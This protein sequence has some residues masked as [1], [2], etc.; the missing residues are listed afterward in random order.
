MKKK[1]I[2]IL[3]STGSIGIQAL[4]IIEHYSD[5]FRVV[6]LSTKGNIRLLK[7]Q[8]LKFK[9][10]IVSVEDEKLRKVLVKELPARKPE[11]LCNQE[12]LTSIA[13]HKETDVVMVAVVGSVALL[14]VVSAIN[15]GKDIALANKEALVVGGN[16][17][18][19][20][21][22]KKGVKILPVDSEQSAI[23]QC[24]EGNKR[25]MVKKIYLT[26]SGGPFYNRHPDSF[27]NISIEDALKH[28]RWSMGKKISIDSASMM[29]KGLEI[30]EAKWLFDI[31]IDRIEIII[32]PQ[33]IIHSMVEYLDGSIIAQ[34][35]ITD[36]RVPILYALTYPERIDSYLPRLNLIDVSPLS[37]ERPDL[38]K[39]PI[40]EYAYD[41][42]RIGKSMP[43]VLNASNEVAVKYFLKK[44]IGFMDISAIIRYMLDKHVP[45]ETE[46]IK[47]IIEI[48]NKIKKETEEVVLNRKWR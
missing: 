17:I 47:K 16:V 18:K 32:H 19:K 25:N 22:E 40:I 14:P 4:E 38:N 28:P 7:E 5:Y 44:L 34:M 3:G 35:A 42:C 2:T 29:N 39:F 23:F 15:A 10:S 1:N 12:G 13:S 48:D 8:I 11:I 20:L 46:D 33:S 41:A 43:I 6:G 36:M 37:F 21:A 24:L 26:A 27:K 9:P 45:V 31:D 30:I